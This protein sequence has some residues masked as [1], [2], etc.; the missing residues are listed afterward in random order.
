VDDG[1]SSQQRQHTAAVAILLTAA[2]WI[3]SVSYVI[4]RDW[5]LLL[6]FDRSPL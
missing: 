1:F 5:R 4:V 6:S 2:E 3:T